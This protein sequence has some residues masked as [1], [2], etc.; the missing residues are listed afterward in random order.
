[1]EPE[2]SAS[3]SM[4]LPTLVGPK[5]RLNNSDH[6]RYPSLEN[7]PGPTIMKKSRGKLGR[8]RP[9]TP[10][11]NASTPTPTAKFAMPSTSTPTPTSQATVPSTAGSTAT[12]LHHTV[13]PGTSSTNRPSSLHQAVLGKQEEAMI[14]AMKETGE[15]MKT[16][17]EKIKAEANMGL[18]REDGGDAKPRG[19]TGAWP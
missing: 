8:Y 14:E 17:G 6:H 11:P 5:K 1:M 2:G 16:A 3:P 9:S 15:K 12:V 18:K 19:Y 13:R 10:G 4:S 7:G